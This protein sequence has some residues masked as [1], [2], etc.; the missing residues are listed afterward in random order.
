MLELSTLSFH[1]ACSSYPG[2]TVHCDWP[3]TQST[4]RVVNHSLRSWVRYHT[5]EPTVL[6]RLSVP[7]IPLN[8]DK[9]HQPLLL[10]W[11]TSLVELNATEQGQVRTVIS[12]ITW[13]P[14]TCSCKRPSLFPCVEQ[15]VLTTPASCCFALP[16]SCGHPAEKVFARRFGTL[17]SPPPPVEGI[18]WELHHLCQSDVVSRVTVLNSILKHRDSKGFRFSECWS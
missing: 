8:V 15:E 13:R 3:A 1:N 12:R 18:P 4:D 10:H 9:F 6:S 2:L 11:R 17:A 14:L 5:Q 7:P 16:P